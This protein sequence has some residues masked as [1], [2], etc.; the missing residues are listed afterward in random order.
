MRGGTGACG[1]S[2]SHLKAISPLKEIIV[3]IYEEPASC[4]LREKVRACG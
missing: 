4:D 2:D 1:I 3:N